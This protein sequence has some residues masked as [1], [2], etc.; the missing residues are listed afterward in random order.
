M[1]KK[2]ILLKVP[3]DIYNKISEKAGKGKVTEYIL[4]SIKK[5]LE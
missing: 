5:S 3:S 4:E 1:E 2:A